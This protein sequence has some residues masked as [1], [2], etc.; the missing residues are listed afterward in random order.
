V[1][2]SSPPLPCGECFR[3]RFE[4]AIGARRGKERRRPNRGVTANLPDVSR[5]FFSF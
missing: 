4:V 5:T 3:A 1:R 2:K